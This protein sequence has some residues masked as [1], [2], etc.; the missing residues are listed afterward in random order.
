MLFVLNWKAAI[1]RHDATD[2]AKGLA[3]FT[4]S[5]NYSHKINVAIAPPYPMIQE[6]SSIVAGCGI[7]VA[8]QDCSEFEPGSYTGAVSTKTLWEYGCQYVIIG[9]SERHKYFGETSDTMAKKITRVIRH[10]MIPIVC[11]GD[12]HSEEN[13]Q[14][15]MDDVTEQLK[16]CF[17]SIDK[18]LIQNTSNLVIAY[19]PVWAIGSNR[20]PSIE[21]IETMQNHIKNFMLSSFSINENHLEILYGGS[22]NL[23]NF[24]DLIKSNI[25]GLLIGRAS[26]TYRE[27][28]KIL[29]FAFGYNKVLTTIQSQ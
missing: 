17:G 4:A 7:K 20:A 9:H 8:A 26:L 13:L 27:I 22:V 14:H 28:A 25:G 18:N 11:V 12:N 24:R 5:Q 21:H 19:E 23:E 6:I 2:L 1:A 10:D 29:S 15:A 3:S 16:A